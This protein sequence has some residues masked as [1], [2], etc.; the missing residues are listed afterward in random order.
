MLDELIDYAHSQLMAYASMILTLEVAWFKAAVLGGLG[1][2]GSER[3][4]IRGVGLHVTE[5]GYDG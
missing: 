3:K 1:N 5:E 2:I 4:I